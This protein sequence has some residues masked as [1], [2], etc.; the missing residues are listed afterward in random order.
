MRGR[1]PRHERCDTPDPCESRVTSMADD[2]RP[3]NGAEKVTVSRA[4]LRLELLE[5]EIRLK[6]YL[7]GRLS[8]IETDIRALQEVNRARDAAELVLANDAE[9]RRGEIERAR[10]ERAAALEAPV[11]TWNLRAS[12]ATVAYGLIAFVLACY[13]LYGIFHR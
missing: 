11:R 1:W 2:D 6:E 10:Q 13:T 9:R 5:L 7:T 4:A 3:A 8:V 12:K